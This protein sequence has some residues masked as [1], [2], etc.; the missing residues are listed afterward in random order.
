M[1]AGKHNHQLTARRGENIVL[2]LRLGL[3]ELASIYPKSVLMSYA[4]NLIIWHKLP[5]MP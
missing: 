3:A 2:R 5:L 1:C 4:K